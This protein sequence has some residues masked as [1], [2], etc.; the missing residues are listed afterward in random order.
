[1]KPITPKEWADRLTESAARWGWTRD[2]PIAWVMLSCEVQ[3]EKIAADILKKIG[4]AASA[5]TFGRWK[6]AS[7]YTERN[8]VLGD[9]ILMPGVVF[10]KL[11]ASVNWVGLFD[12]KPLRRVVC[13]NGKPITLN[14]GELRE[15]EDIAAR[16]CQKPHHK[17]MPTN[18][19]FEVGDT[20]EFLAGPLEGYKVDV[21]SLD[22]RTAR[23]LVS[24]F[25]R[26]VETDVASLGKL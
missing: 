14:D 20:A 1:M 19:I 8:K 11:P 2:E 12:L 6:K 9:K 25:G 16:L 7:R 26:E 13:P 10:A 15:V 24:A 18:L 5:P 23:V 4:L 21:K 17:P 3:K 22:G